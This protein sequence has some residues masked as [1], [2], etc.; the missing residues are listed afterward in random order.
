M[1][2]FHLFLKFPTDIHSVIMSLCLP[3]DLVC[4]RLTWYVLCAQTI[5]N[6][7][8]KQS[9]K[10]LYN[11]SSFKPS[12]PIRLRQDDSVSSVLGFPPPL[13]GFNEAEQGKN[14]EIRCRH[15]KTCHELSHKEICRRRDSSAYRPQHWVDVQLRHTYPTATV[16]PGRNCCISAL[17]GGCQRG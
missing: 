11:L 13:C 9:S 4:L 3:N 6:V 8:L 16:F 1:S 15:Q 17:E 2:E 14:Y 12:R 10:Y 7:Y 5:A